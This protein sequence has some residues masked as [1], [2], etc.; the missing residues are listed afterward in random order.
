[1]RRP[2]SATAER[3]VD[4]CQGLLRIAPPLQCAIGASA[5]IRASHDPAP[6]L[7]ARQVRSKARLHEPAGSR[8]SELPGVSYLELPRK[9]AEL[10]GTGRSRRGPRP[11]PLTVGLAVMSL[12]GIF[13]AGC[14]GG[15]AQV[16]PPHSAAEQA[17]ALNWLAQTNQMWTR[18]NFAAL[19]HVTTGQMRTIYLSEENQASLPVN[20]AGPG[21]AGRADGYQAWNPPAFWRIMRKQKVT[22][23]GGRVAAG[24]I[25][26]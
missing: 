23:L 9:D 25:L 7:P 6:G 11:L 18:A 12:T 22:V 17:A 16:N 10:N 15:G 4:R 19:D 8:S 24:R 5:G 14:S 1:M 26:L 20:A 21:L 13:L 3:L 2:R